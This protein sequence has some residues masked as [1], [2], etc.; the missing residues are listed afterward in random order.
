MRLTFLLALL[1]YGLF[2]QEQV[3]DIDNYDVINPTEIDQKM[4]FTVINGVQYLVEEHEDIIISRWQN[5]NFEKLYELENLYPEKTKLSANDDYDEFLLI[6]DGKY[7][8]ITDQ[9]LEVIDIVT[10]VRERNIDY[11]QF[12]LFFRKINDV[13]GSRILMTANRYD[14]DRLLVFDL[15][16]SKFVY[17][18]NYL[19]RVGFKILEDRVI[20]MNEDSTAVGEWLFSDFSNRRIYT[21]NDKIHTWSSSEKDQSVTVL[22]SLGSI[23]RVFKDS[24]TVTFD[25]EVTD[26]L[27]DDEF[28]F[29]TDRYIRINNGMTNI[30]TPDIEVVNLNNCQIENSFRTNVN[31]SNYNNSIILTKNRFADESFTIFAQYGV[32]FGAEQFIINHND[33][34]ISPLAFSFRVIDYSPIIQDGSI[35]LSAENNLDFETYDRHF[36]R[37]DLSTKETKFL[38]PNSSPGFGLT[39]IVGYPEDEG[40]VVAY[41]TYQ[42][43]PAIYSLDED[44]IFT[45]IQALNYDSKLGFNNIYNVNVHEDKLYVHSRRNIHEVGNSTNFLSKSEEAFQNRFS[46]YSII[47]FTEYEDKVAFA[48]TD[49]SDSL[50]LYMYETTSEKLDSLRPPSGFGNSLNSIKNIGP[51]LTSGSHYYNLRDNTFGV[52]DDDVSFYDYGIGMDKVTF[53]NRNTSNSY[54]VGVLD[55]NSL[56]IDLYNFGLTNPEIY[57]GFDNTAYI[58]DAENFSRLVLYFLNSSGELEFLYSIDNANFI[59]R[60]FLSS[61]NGTQN[62]IKNE[63][64]NKKLNNF[65]FIDRDADKV[66]IVSHDTNTSYINEYEN[67]DNRTIISD[68]WDDGYFVK[69]SNALSYFSIAS[70]VENI[71]TLDTSESL[72]GELLQGDSI[73]VFTI[74]DDTASTHE[75]LKY[76][77]GLGVIENRVDINSNIECEDLN[78]M[79]FLSDDSVLCYCVN[80]FSDIKLVVVDVSDGSIDFIDNPNSNIQQILTHIGLYDVGSY[81][82]FPAIILDGSTQWFR[83]DKNNY[84]LNPVPEEVEEVKSIMTIPTVSSDVIQLE[85]SFDQFTILNKNGDVM[86]VY[87][88]YIQDRQIDISAYSD[89]MY[90]II[91]LDVTS[92][93]VRQ[94]TFIKM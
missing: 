8:R 48:A 3:S 30:N 67:V 59:G 4:K 83:V 10:G 25:C 58:V 77:I 71:Y 91:S 63:V 60:S 2:A 26:I 90:Y 17:L 92:G 16:I 89:G 76:N 41:N 86:D 75:I 85:E 29:F 55:I 33:H 43:N 68:E 47:G 5:G 22:E 39:A 72:D 31:S 15:S 64:S 7:V 62:F 18:P 34:S 84:N 21:S 32:G 11:T 28:H 66:I 53:S 93:K 65:E 46:T 13:V 74:T 14:E 6:A 49:A 61:S 69:E 1:T 35:Y 27:P 19:F 73:V 50:M 79:A 42:E 54:D 94:G 52:F 82:Y 51:L 23:H 9:T 81:V 44:D 37:H 12:R 56:E 70:G 40:M 24:I 20:Y 36:L 45:E 87:S 57:S 38:A 88:S 78:P 80:G